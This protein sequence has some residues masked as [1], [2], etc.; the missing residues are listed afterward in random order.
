MFVDLEKL[1]TAGAN[2]HGQDPFDHMVID[3]FFEPEVAEGLEK[4]F[5]DFESPVWHKYNN[6]IEIKKTCNNWNVFPSLTYRVLEYLNSAEFMQVLERSCG[7]EMLHSDVG[8]NGGGWHVHKRGGKLNT[9]LDYN[10]HP[11]TGLQRKLNII[12]YLNS[13]WQPSWGGQLGM[14]EEDDQRRRPGKLTKS[15][16]PVFNRAVIFDTTQRSWHGLPAPL[17]CPEGQTRRSLAV[18]Y[19]I[20]PPEQTED[21]GKALF[22]PFEEQEN[23]E[24]VLALIAAR[25]RSDSAASVYQSGNKEEG[26]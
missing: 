2:F 9:H 17:E 23:D 25:A 11:K 26:G 16:D 12:V 20:P 18:Y 22:S 21:R 7:I 8:L 3:G 5:P 15:V 6:A 14:W 10:L 24:A 1:Q 4:E 13:A 19:L